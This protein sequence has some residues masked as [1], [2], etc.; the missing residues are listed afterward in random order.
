MCVCVY[1]RVF[2]QKST[3]LYLGARKNTI[4]LHSIRTL[5]AQGAVVLYITAYKDVFMLTCI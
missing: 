5:N 2:E 1:V 4:L 3:Y